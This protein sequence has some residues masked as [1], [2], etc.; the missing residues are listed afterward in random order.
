MPG[1]TGHEVAEAIRKLDRGDE[2]KLV[3]CSSISH[4]VTVS[5]GVGTQFDAVLFKPLVQATLL[6]TLT[7]VFCDNPLAWEA[8]GRV[9]DARLAGAEILLVEDNE[10]NMY[11][12]TIMLAQLGCKVTTARSGLE[13]V[14]EA[15]AK[16]FDLILMDMQMPEMD[17]LEASRHIRAAAGPNQTKPI[18]A[19]TANAFV[20]DAA[21][22]KAAG[23]NE[24]LTKPIR[25]HV[26]E[27]A[28]QRYLTGR[29][30][31]APEKPVLCAR[32]W[33]DLNADMPAEAVKKLASTF[34]TNQTRELSAMRE[35]IAKGDRDTLRRRAHSL[36]GAARLLGATSLGEA[37]MALEEVVE[38]IEAEA[39]LKRVAALDQ[40]FAEASK[41][42][43]AKLPTSVAA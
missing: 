30:S 27:A 15:A 24:H 12:A 1:Q 13:A 8:G 34:M 9:N 43:T 28:L 29:K 38:T 25:R 18:L 6:E 36:K 26:L 20:E 5:A 14:R 41:A 32:T 17:G 7:N 11:A 37:A 3:L 2:I 23:M 4:G 19:L 33:A 22:C 16:A 21:R 40:L 10:T 42:L 31:A 39:A 35:D